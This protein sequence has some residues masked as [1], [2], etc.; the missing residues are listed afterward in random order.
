M[1]VVLKLLL[2]LECEGICNTP[3][4]KKFY[5]K[6]PYRTPL[7]EIDLSAIINFATFGIIM[8][9]VL[10]CRTNYVHLACLFYSI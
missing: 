2:R 7:V 9:L 3:N 8:Y 5:N 10:I 1:Y 6:L 4:I